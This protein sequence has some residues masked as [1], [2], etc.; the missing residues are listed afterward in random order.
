MASFDV[1]EQG[2]IPVET[3]DG[4]ME[5]LG[6]LQV[7]ERASE[8]KEI[9]D[10]SPMVEYGLYRFLQVFLMDALRPEETYE[11]EDILDKKKFDMDKILEYITLCKQEG[12][13]FDLY[14]SKRP[15]L[16][17]TYDEQWDKKKKSIRKLDYT[18]PSGNNH[19]HFDHRAENQI[20]FSSAEAAKLLPANLL[21]CTVMAQEYPSG[22]NDTPPYF[23][24]IEGENLFETLCYTLVPKNHYGM[25]SFDDPPALW[26]YQKPI[27]PKKKIPSEECSWLFGMLFPT[28]RIRLIEPTEEDKVQF[29]IWCQGMNC[30]DEDKDKD[31]DKRKNAWVDPCVTYQY[32]VDGIKALC[33]KRSEA[34]WR[35][36]YDLIDTLEDPK[37]KVCHAPI[38]LGSYKNMGKSGNTVHMILYGVETNRARYIQTMRHSLKFPIKLVDNNCAQML[39]NMVTDAEALRKKL[40]SS[41]KETKAAPK[42]TIISAIQQYYDWCEKDFW[43]ICNRLSD[44]KQDADKL[45]EQWNNCIVEYAWHAYQEAFSRIILR[46]R[47]WS[48][49]SK[50]ELKF[51][52]SIKKKTRRKK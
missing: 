16:Q 8:L 51:I 11:I 21:F 12:V 7:L 6:I 49:V 14:D 31:K 10:S 19:T 22:M 25:D 20:Y 1:L 38:I 34:I 33:P 35:N 28:R 47:Q 18:I 30:K 24:V 45:Y 15:F 17:A 23:A 9:K 13:S 44:N 29:M 27:V 5:L 37:R 26:R 43:D 42:H 32:T 3:L 48:A 39:R 4:K 52:K 50:E 46:A 36:F 41:L 40:E 2:W